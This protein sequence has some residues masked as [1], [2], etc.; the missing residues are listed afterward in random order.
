MEY[1]GRGKSLIVVEEYDKQ[2]I[3]LLLVKVSRYLNLG[4]EESLT[5]LAL[6]NDDYS[7]GVATFIKEASLF[8]VKM[9]LI[10]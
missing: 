2:V 3:V 7:W 9:E 4:H 5:P 10:L 6:S 8:L 1:V